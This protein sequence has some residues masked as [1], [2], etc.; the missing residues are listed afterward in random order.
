M[1]RNADDFKKLPTVYFNVNSQTG[2]DAASY[3]MMFIPLHVKQLHQYIT[4]H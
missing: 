1:Q 3:T 2:S 4:L